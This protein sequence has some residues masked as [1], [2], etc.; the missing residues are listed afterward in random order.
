MV[1]YLF[2]IFYTCI[3]YNYSISHKV[4]KVGGKNNFWSRSSRWVPRA[5]RA[6]KS[7]YKNIFSAPTSSDSIETS[8]SLI[9]W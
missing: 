2:I 7:G 6:K 9:D 4:A 3:Y 5:Y 1:N 8:N